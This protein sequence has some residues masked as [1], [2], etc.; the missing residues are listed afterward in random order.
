MDAI[1]GPAE[2]VPV[3][4]ANQKDVKPQA[5]PHRNLLDHYKGLTLS[6]QFNVLGEHGVV[7]D[8]TSLIQL[9]AADRRW[10]NHRIRS[11]DTGTPTHAL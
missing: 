1:L 4:T 2:G 3:P 8:P 10:S 7:Y 11:L 9:A 5:K 6:L